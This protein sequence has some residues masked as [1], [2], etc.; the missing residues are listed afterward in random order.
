V[1]YVA[2]GLPFMI[3]C[4]WVSALVMFPMKFMSLAVGWKGD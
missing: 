1:A 4:L 3:G 2:Y